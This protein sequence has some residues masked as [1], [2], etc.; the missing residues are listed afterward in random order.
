MQE[1][2]IKILKP[3]GESEYKLL[4]SFEYNNSQYIVIDSKEKDSNMNTIVYISKVN[5]KEL[6]NVVE[7]SEW[8]S[9][10]NAL[11]SVVKQE[12]GVVLKTVENSEYNASE[13]IGHPLALHEKHLIKINESYSKFN[14]QVMENESINQ[15]EVTPIQEVAEPQVEI[16]SDVI[17]PIVEEQ[18]MVEQTM[19]PIVDI[20]EP[21]PVVDINI[22]VQEV[23]EPQV[24]ISSDVIQPIVEEQPIVEQKNY[25]ANENAVVPEDVEQLVNVIKEN[26]N[27]LEQRLNSWK[28]ELVKK[29]QELNEKEERLNKQEVEISELR[30]QTNENYETAKAQLEVAN[31]AFENSKKI[32]QEEKTEEVYL[33]DMIDTFQTDVSKKL[34]LAA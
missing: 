28:E 21:Q 30:K 3:S 18:P 8:Q 20:V 34:E 26:C 16:S 7:E 23:A 24:E 2:N 15:P 4:V 11:I 31:I 1:K 17:Q 27:K 14:E 22:P 9:V 13:N 19:S 33:N 32:N 6:E 10:R 12:D 29:E 25:S 5:G